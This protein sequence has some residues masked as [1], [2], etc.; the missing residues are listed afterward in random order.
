MAQNQEKRRASENALA[1]CHTQKL[2]S[3]LQSQRPR[4]LLHSQPCWGSSTGCRFAA[5]CC[6]CQRRTRRPRA[7][8]KAA[9]C[10]QRHSQPGRLSGAATSGSRGLLVMVRAPSRPVGAQHLTE[11]GRV[12]RSAGARVCHVCAVRAA[13]RAAGV[14][15]GRGRAGRD[16][17][18]L[19]RGVARRRFCRGMCVLVWRQLSPRERLVRVR[20]H[21][22]NCAASPQVAHRGGGAAS[23]IGEQEAPLWGD[24][25]PEGERAEPEPVQAPE[26][27]APV[28]AVLAA[29]RA[30]CAQRRRHVLRARCALATTK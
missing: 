20:T 5:V 21:A 6:C 2:G 18:G 3:F 22:L 8:F 15:S 23:F 28:P 26:A 13:G 1:A 29:P 27:T 14:A 19:G 9:C 25:P 30:R 16:A 10:S 17:R 11:P 24:E 7:T 4:R 12:R